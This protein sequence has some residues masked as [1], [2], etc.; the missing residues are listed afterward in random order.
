MAVELEKITAVLIT[1]QPTYPERVLSS[2]VGKPFGGIVIETNCKGVYR[3]FEMAEFVHT[4]FV[5]VQDD[6]CICP[7]R[8]IAEEAQPE[9]M[10]CAMK[11]HYIHTYVNLKCAL[12]GWGT[13]FPRHMLSVLDEYIS[14]YGE[15]D[16]VY[17]K[18]TDRIFTALNYP[19]RRIPMGIV[20]TADAT[21]PDRMSYDPD[22]YRIR[23]EALK[24]CESL[25]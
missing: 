9:E 2:I 8:E 10:T 13:I 7:I 15:E 4:P 6:D 12:V 16:E 25:R 22:H 24:R 21:A 1:K 18:G 14:I 23:E 17:R 11:P 20:D 5:Y 19:Q 3:R